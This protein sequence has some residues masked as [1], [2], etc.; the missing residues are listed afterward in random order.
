MTYAD[1]FNRGYA[2]GL[3]QAGKLLAYYGPV[4]MAAVVAYE[5]AHCADKEFN[6]HY[7]GYV[8]ALVAGSFGI[9]LPCSN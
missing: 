2:T 3:G 6:A 7:H 5:R 1:R 8:A 4:D 9:A